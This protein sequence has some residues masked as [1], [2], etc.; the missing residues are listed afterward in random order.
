MSFQVRVEPGGLQFEAAPG[1]RLV[2]AAQHAGIELPSSCRNNT[3]R[4]CICQVRSGHVRHLID[5]PGLSAD[6]KAD[7]WIL[8]CVAEALSDLT[9]DV[10]LAY[11]MF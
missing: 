7:Q 2:L 4:S 8:P 9:L 6:E 10:P 3:C 1:E 11:S 5:W